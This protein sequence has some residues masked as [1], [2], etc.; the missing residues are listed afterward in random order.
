MAV[1]LRIRQSKNLLKIAGRDTVGK[2][3]S[4]FNKIREFSRPITEAGF[5]LE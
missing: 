4:V 5:V 2:S 3:E 1:I